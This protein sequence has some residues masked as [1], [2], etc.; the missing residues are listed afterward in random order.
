MANLKIIRTWE[1]GYDVI[2]HP[3]KYNGF[4]GISLTS[5]YY[6]KKNI[7]SYI[8][9]GIKNFEKF[10]LFPVDIPYRYN[11]IVFEG[12][13]E[14]DAYAKAKKLGD[15]LERYLYKILRNISVEKEIKILRWE[16]LIK[17]EKALRILN[18]FEKLIY[19]SKELNEDIRN[20]ILEQSPHIEKRLLNNKKIGNFNIK[21]QRKT[22][23]RFLMDEIAMFIFIQEFLGYKIRLS[24]YPESNII[25]NIYNNKYFDF[26]KFGIDGEIGQIQLK[27]DD[28]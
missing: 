22:L 28:G 4:L 11:Y 1:L 27:R 20:H 21:T 23:Y 24:G 17:N 6:K 25:I 2:S 5:P 14:K 12:L 19:E 9:F 7:L 8:E 13:S 3:K 18:Y 26:K 16:D 15:D 10:M